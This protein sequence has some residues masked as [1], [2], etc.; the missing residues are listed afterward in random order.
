MTLYAEAARL[1]LVVFF[2]CGRAGIEPEADQR[3]NQV[4]F[5]EP[6]LRRFPELAIVLGHSGARDVAEVIPMA[7]RH[8]RV[9][10]G[11]HG[12]SV[13]RLAELVE[14]VGGDRLLFGTDWP[15][16]HLAASHAKVL[17]VSRGKPALR[18]A[19][20]RGNAEHLLGA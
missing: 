7:L 3:Y 15:F 9:W 18:R 2:H 19:L 5:F 20:L 4:R 13:T 14:R 10:L 8:P 12:Q 1:G 17:L 16:Y 11:I 6:V